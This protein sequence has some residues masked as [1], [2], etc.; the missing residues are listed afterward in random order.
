M[1]VLSSFG[2]GCVV[3]NVRVSFKPRDTAS[4]H[5]PLLVA[6]DGLDS[7]RTVTQW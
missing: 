7:I 2:L 4:D 1:H 5:E 6:A 3:G